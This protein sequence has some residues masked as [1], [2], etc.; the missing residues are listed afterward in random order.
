MILKDTG[1]RDNRWIGVNTTAIDFSVAGPAALDTPLL[2]T[3]VELE[4]TQFATSP[5]GIDGLKK[6]TWNLNGVDQPGTTLN[7]YRPSGLAPS[8]DYTVKVKHEGYRLGESEWSP[9]ITLKTGTTRNLQDYYVK[10]I[11]EL[12]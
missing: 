10:Q 2:T 6:I 7:P 12:F 1:T 9:S 11:E 5:A 3:N 8:T 4:S